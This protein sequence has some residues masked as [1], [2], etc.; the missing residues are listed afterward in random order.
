MCKCESVY[1]LTFIFLICIYIYILCE[2]ASEGIMCKLVIVVLALARAPS[3]VVLSGP[4][5]HGW[6]GSVPCSAGRISPSGV[7][8]WHGYLFGLIRV[9]LK[10]VRPERARAG[11]DHAARLDIYTHAHL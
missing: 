11:P 8:A 4:A 10:W 2:C 5:R 9:G 6:A 7:T 1:I 3:W